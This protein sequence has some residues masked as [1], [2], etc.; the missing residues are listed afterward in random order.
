M[1][2]INYSVLRFLKYDVQKSYKYLPLVGIGTK[3]VFCRCAL[4]VPTVAYCLAKWLAV[5]S[6]ATGAE[7]NVLNDKTHT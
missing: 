4:M 7:C 1:L 6:V 5:V 2:T 3:C